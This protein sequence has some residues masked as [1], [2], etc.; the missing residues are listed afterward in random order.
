M[1]GMSSNFSVSLLPLCT[2]DLAL[3]LAQLALAHVARCTTC[4]LA[5]VT[6][7]TTTRAPPTTTFSLITHASG[8]SSYPV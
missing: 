7:H 3:A 1:V 2:L 4:T 8:A 5:L 6:T